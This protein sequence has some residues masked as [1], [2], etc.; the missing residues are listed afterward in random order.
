[1]TFAEL[2]ATALGWTLCLSLGST[3][4]A[5]ILGVPLGYWIRTLPVRIRAL[6]TPILALPFFLPSLLIGVIAVPFLNRDETEAATLAL[7][8]TA[9]QGFINIGFVALTVSASLSGIPAAQREAATLEGAGKARIALQIELPQLR[10]AL[11]AVGVLIALYS[12]T[13]YSLA[14]LVGRGYIST[15]EIEIAKFAFQDIDYAAALVFGLVHLLLTTSMF[16]IASK[17]GGDSLGFNLFGE[18]STVDRWDSKTS[19]TRSRALLSGLGVA[20]TA[21]VT[22]ALL[23]PVIRSF[24][25]PDGIGLANYLN[26]GSRGERQILD[27]TLAQA[28]LNSL[29]NLVLT[30][31]I[32]LPVAWLLARVRGPGRRFANPAGIWP[33]AISP[34]VLG[35]SVL[36]F[37]S[38]LGIRA[39]E[40]WILLPATQALVVLPLLTVLFRAAYDSMDS[41]LRD[42]ATVDGASGFQSWW[43]VELPALRAPLASGILFASL[44]AIGEFSAAS[45]LTVGSQTTLPVAMYQLAARPGAEN[46]GMA[47]AAATL[48]ILFALSVLII[49][50]RIAKN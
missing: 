47:M 31:L 6:V 13:N 12:A 35:M 28:T 21:L 38:H 42:A 25:T 33:A 40:S 29:R 37:S 26:L 32:A 27:V 20:A 15:L 46:I 41:D 22:L 18:E 23:S 19:E 49:Q 1:M 36:A 17:L 24:I 39:T 45:F 11:A 2:L 5:L 44:A 48:F 3:C 16:L 7:T 50:R 34:V 30:L 8:L 4:F 10:S 43:L 9:I 14:A